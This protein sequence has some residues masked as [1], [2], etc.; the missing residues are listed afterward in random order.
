MSLDGLY[1]NK[2]DETHKYFLFLSIVYN[3]FNTSWKANFHQAHWFVFIELL[4]V[5]FMSFD[6]NSATLNQQQSK[7]NFYLFSLNS[8]CCMKKRE[9]CSGLFFFHVG[10]KEIGY[11][12]F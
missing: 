11:K 10:L 1:V 9:N 3:T 5:R 12:S 2:V 4:L 7:L 6:L 8:T